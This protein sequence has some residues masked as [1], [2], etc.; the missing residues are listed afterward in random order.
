M[1]C[2][3]GSLITQIQWWKMAIMQSWTLMCSFSV[4][5]KTSTYV[6]CI[7]LNSTCLNVYF[8]RS[9]KPRDDK[10]SSSANDWSF[11]RWS[12]CELNIVCR[13][14]LICR[15]SNMDIDFLI[16][17]S[18]PSADDVFNTNYLTNISS[19]Y[20]SETHIIMIYVNQT[21]LF[22]PSSFCFQLLNLSRI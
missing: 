12:H 9:I 4:N 1:L 22:P 15:G 16:V 5:H 21:P 6:P 3:C 2:F 11:I 19:Y 18:Y 13:R 8:S 14:A 20:A 10:W 17:S 7:K